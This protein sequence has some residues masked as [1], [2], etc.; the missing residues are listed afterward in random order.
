[1]RSSRASRTTRPRCAPVTCSRRCRA[2]ARTVPSSPAGR[3]GRRRRRA[4]R[5]GRAAAPA[6]R[7]RRCPV[8]VDP[9]PRAVLGALAAAVY[10]DPTARLAVLGVTGTNG[11]TTT[12]YLLEAGLRAA[13]RAHRADRHRRDP[14]RRRVGCRACRTTPE[15]PDLQA[16]FAVMRERG[17]HRRSRWR[18]PATRWRWA[19]ST[20]PGSP[21]ARSPTSPRTTS[22]S[23]RDMEDYFAAKALAVRRARRAEVVSVD[24]ECGRA[25]GRAAATVTV[26]AAG[27]PGRRLA[28]GRRRHRPGR[29][30]AG[31]AVLG[32]DGVDLPAR[33]RLPGAFNVANALLALA[34]P[35]RGRRAAAVAAA[36]A[37][38]PRRGVPGRMQRVDAGQPFLARG[39]LRAQARTRSRALLDALRARRDRRADHRR[40]RRGGDRDRGKRPLMGAAAAARRRR[41]GGH[42]RQPAL[43]GPGG[44]PGRDAGRGAAAVPADRGEVRRD[45]R[46]ARGDRR[47]GRAGPGPATRSWSPARATRPG[48]R[49]PAWCIPFDDRGGAAPAALAGCRGAADDRDDAWPRSPPS[50]GGRLHDAPTGDALVTGAVEFDSRAVAPGRAV[51][52]PAG[53]A[54]RRARLRRRGGRAAGAGRRVLARPAGRR[55]RAVAASPRRAGRRSARAGR[56]AGRRTALP[57]GRRVVGRHR[58]VA[59]RPRPRTCSPQCSAAAG[60]DGRAARVVQQRARPSR[61]PCCAPTRTPGYL[62]LEMRRARARAHRRAVPRSR[63]PGSAW[64]STSARAHLG[65]FG[66]RRGDRRGQGR[67]GRGAA[68][69]DGRRGAQRRRPAGARRWPRAPPP[70]WSPSAWRAAA[71]VR[72]DGRRRWTSAAGPRSGWS[73]AGRVGAGRAA[74]GRR[75][76]GRQ[77]AGRRRG[78]ARA[79][80]AARRRWPTR[81]PRPRRVAGGG[82]RSPSAPDGVTVVNDAYNA[83]PESMRAALRALA[84]IGA[85]AGG[86]G[87][88]SARWPSWARPRPPSTTRSA[89]WPPSSASTGSWSSGRTAPRGAR[90]AARGRSVH[91]DG[92]D[93]A[94][95]AAARPSCARGRRAG[96]GVAGRPAWNGSRAL[97]LA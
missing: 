97:P 19:G 36:G 59:A 51:R 64:C 8:L 2:R 26:S 79:R 56:A 41:A 48:R 72:A 78:R 53:R 54:G 61:A 86:P 57:A 85:A 62:V 75:A 38:R 45:R 21:S 50:V 31:F 16:L 15:A 14:G 28:G 40:A 67:A 35:G 96:E 68:G 20:A 39:R 84:A 24:D 90:G 92:A 23:T 25:A 1:M 5:P 60:P 88:C 42:R 94:V 55:R 17:V 33:L 93:A 13:G 83:N 70:G 46:P 80:A 29:R 63:R 76:P 52:R 95:D 11:K 7:D 18:C 87:R 58:L 27:R 12:A 47:G 82:W 91:V 89:S 74:A 44:D 66:C 73:T 6:V 34:L 3:G 49:S 77:R 37:W 69:A 22:T 71:D 4:H 10:G 30:P 9:T 65:E 32:P 43:G 81:W